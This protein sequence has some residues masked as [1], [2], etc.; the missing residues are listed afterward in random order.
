LSIQITSVAYEDLAD[1]AALHV[2]SW[3][4]TYTG[5]MPQSYLDGMDVKDR[6]RKWQAG[7]DAVESGTQALFLAKLSG[8]AVGFASIGPA[9][10]HD[11]E[12]LAE[13]YAVYVLKHHWHQGIGYGLFREASGWF[14]SKGFT[15]AYVWVLDTNR[16]AIQS[17][18]KWGGRLN[19]SRFKEEE[20]AGQI[21]KEQEITFTNFG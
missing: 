16:N 3:K 15:Q 2:R 7:Y 20:I 12:G 21:I 9:R 5:L 1:V 11:R 4:E 10:E 17:Y 6:L 13:I 8:K 19:S 18:R 14:K